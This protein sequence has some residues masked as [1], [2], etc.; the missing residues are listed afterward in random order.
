[1]TKMFIHNIWMTKTF[2]CVFLAILT[3]PLS[4]SSQNWLNGQG[5]C[6]QDRI[7]P[8][9]GSLADTPS[10]WFEIDDSD[11]L[12]TPEWNFNYTNLKRF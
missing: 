2:I 12:I 10:P 4:L 6:L 5:L 8:P 7:M 9:E 3:L 1:M 11:E